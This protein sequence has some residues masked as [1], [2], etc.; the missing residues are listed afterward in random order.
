MSNRIDT[1]FE[2]CRAEERKA[3]VLFATAGDPSLPFTER[4]LPRLA[5]AGADI[6]EVGV[7]FSDPMADGPTIQ[8]ASQRALAAGTTLE[9]I[10]E[11][12]ARLRRDGLDTPIVLF[13]YCN[14]LLQYGA[15]RL[16]QRAAEVGVDGCLV[17]D[18]PAEERDEL[19]PL[20]EAHGLHWINLIAPTTPPERAR[21]LLED[22]SGFTYF[23]TVKGVTGARAALPPDLRAR[24]MQVRDLSPVPVVAGFGVS[25]PEM[26]RTVAETADGV[27]VGSALVRTVNESADEEEALRK[28]G[29]FVAGLGTAMNVGLNARSG[30]PRS[31]IRRRA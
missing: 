12:I 8:A 2:A 15:E 28:A 1:A 10:L 21:R 17:V 23:I 3:L 26:A 13:S 30:A 31:G 19:R 24:V 27:V 29:E 4:L 18:M 16:A 11:M 9:G 5:E 14:V 6:L 22:A 25:S 20:L 7:P